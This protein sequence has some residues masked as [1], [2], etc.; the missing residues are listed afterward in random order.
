M[1]REE[2][3]QFE[4]YINIA[5]CLRVIPFE[6]RREKTSLRGFQPG[7]LQIDLYSHRR[8]LES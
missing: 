2:D 1:V 6:L 7:L 3:I 8:K 5:N 4:H